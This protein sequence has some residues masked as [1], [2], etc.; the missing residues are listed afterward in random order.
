M[1]NLFLPFCHIQRKL[2]H[3]NHSIHKTTITL[4]LAHFVQHN[5]CYVEVSGSHFASR[6]TLQRIQRNQKAPQTKKKLI[7]TKYTHATPESY[8]SHTLNACPS[9]PFYTASPAITHESHAT[10]PTAPQ[11]QSP[12][13][14]PHTFNTALTV[15]TANTAT[16]KTKPCTYM[17]HT[18]QTQ[19]IQSL[20]HSLT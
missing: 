15:S 3:L 13:E 5:L 18:Y 9:I 20:H 6:N 12:P 1:N 7:S 8:H 19:C 17:Y 16:P 4:R 14:V 11:S 2:S 10:L